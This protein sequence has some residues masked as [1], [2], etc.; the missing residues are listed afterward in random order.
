MYKKIKGIALRVLTMIVFFIGLEGV[1]GIT[2]LA[3]EK[4]KSTRDINEM[5]IALVVLVI[6]VCA[7]GVFAIYQFHKT[8]T[9]FRKER[10]KAKKTLENPSDS[11]W[12]YDNLISRAKI[13][14]RQ[15]NNSLKEDDLS[16]ISGYISEEFSDNIDEKLKN[17]RLEE[18][19]ILKVV[20]IKAIDKIGD[21][22]D[23][24]VLIIKY[25]GLK[26]GYLREEEEIWTYIKKHGVWV[27]DKFEKSNLK[28]DLE[29][30]K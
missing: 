21:S 2:A 26:N 7:R 13:C 27:A 12:I 15:I 9:V 1:F 6:L 8:T 25:K 29:D 4:V 28:I 17:G 14:F 20:P 30:I 24:V 18:I 23:L 5:Y 11:S 10:E 22:E 19:E 3:E 16:I